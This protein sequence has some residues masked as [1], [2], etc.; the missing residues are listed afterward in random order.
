MNKFETYQQKLN[1]IQFIKSYPFLSKLPITILQK[2]LIELVLSFQNN[3]K[4]FEMSYSSISEILSSKNKEVIKVNISQLKKLNFIKTINTKN[5][6][7]VNGGSSTSIIVDED[8]IIN[9][10]NTNNEITTSNELSIQSNT[11]V[12]NESDNLLNDFMSSSDIEIND[13][14]SFINSINESEELVELIIEDT[15]YSDLTYKLTNGTIVKILKHIENNF[16]EILEYKSVVREL[17]SSRN[18]Y[19]FDYTLR[20]KYDSMSLNKQIM[21]NINKQIQIEI[22][23]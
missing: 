19:D 13:S 7:G 12:S 5:Y 23:K 18:Q 9:Y 14:I 20:R 10:I 4:K 21:E 3:N 6:N 15:E 11:K 1:G 17:L 16:N 22:N 8:Y 2:D